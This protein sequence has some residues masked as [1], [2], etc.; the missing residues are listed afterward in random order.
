MERML[1]EIHIL[2]YFCHDEEK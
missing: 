2:P 1:P